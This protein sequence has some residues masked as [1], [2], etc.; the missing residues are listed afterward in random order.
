MKQCEKCIFYDAEFDSL[1]QSGDDIAIEG[2]EN[3][4]KHFCRM[5]DD[6]IPAEVVKDEKEC[7]AFIYK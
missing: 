7:K 1:R 3:E 5:F 2:Q 6:T 4:E